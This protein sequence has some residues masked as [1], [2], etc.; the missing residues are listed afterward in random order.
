MQ[1]WDPRYGWE[2]TT[3]PPPGRPRG[4]DPIRSER[5]LA[6]PQCVMQT[7]AHPFLN[8]SWRRILAR[9]SC[10]TVFS[11]HRWATREPQSSQHRPHASECR[12]DT[13]P[14]AI[15]LYLSPTHMG[16]V[17]ASI[18]PEWLVVH[19]RFASAV[20]H[21]LPTHAQDVFNLGFG[22]ITTR[23]RLKL[24][25]GLIFCFPSTAGMDSSRAHP[26]S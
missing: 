9:C 13:H 11:K 6:K 5:D 24:T 19:T 12:V 7:S 25:V 14:S 22:L 3:I 18:H 20:Y 23:R 16:F 1:G 2:G 26:A 8:A 4:I 17:K 15:Y 10:S 21:L